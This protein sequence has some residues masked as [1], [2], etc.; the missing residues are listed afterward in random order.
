MADLIHALQQFVWGPGML[1]FFLAAGV[2]F[3]VKSKG[4][5]ITKVHIWIK[6]TLG[7][8]KRE[9]GKERTKKAGEKK[10]PFLSFSRSVQLWQPRLEQEILREWRQRWCSAGRGL[11]SGCGSLPFWE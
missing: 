7:S 2:L 9:K 10:I 3:T 6:Y 1:V 4:F 5:Q 11:F 8:L